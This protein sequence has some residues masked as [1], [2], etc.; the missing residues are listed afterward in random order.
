MRNASA[1]E[2][3]S[4]VR[5][6]SMACL[7]AR[8]RDSG[9]MGELQ[10]KPILTPG[11]LNV[12]LSAATAR[13]QLAT[14]WQPAAAAA[15]CTQAIT[16]C[17]SRTI[18]CIIVPQCSHV[19]VKK[20]RPPSRSARWAVSSLRSCPDEKAGP[21]AARITACT[22]RL[23]PIAAKAAISSSSIASERELREAG[24]LSVSKAM[25]SRVSR[26]RIGSCGSVLANATAVTSDS[27]LDIAPQHAR[28]LTATP[29]ENERN[30]K[31]VLIDD[32]D[33]GARASRPH[34]LDVSRMQLS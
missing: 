13:S 20:E 28:A 9:T 22:V 26:R 7:R 5:S 18:A 32:S 2:T 10:N 12:A 3:A 33:H 11:V 34:F 24:R 25:P 29:D 1:A 6:M 21:S 27:S 16:G 4:P 31:Q 23:A 15:P 17:G 30:P 8:L 14:S 19:L